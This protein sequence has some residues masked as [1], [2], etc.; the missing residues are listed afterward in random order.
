[1]NDNIN[2]AQGGNNTQTQGDRTFT[3]DD[4][5]RIVQERLAK[6]KAKSEAAIAQKEQELAKREL[7]LSAKEKLTE[8]GLP[9]ELLDALN[10]SSPEALDKS[11]EILEKIKT[12]Q[13]RTESFT[14]AAPGQT[15]R[16]GYDEGPDAK[17][18][19]AMGLQP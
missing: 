12:V 7:L 16:R 6:E 17:V 11:L 10:I 4:V 14:G 8:K 19:K 5:N 9:L 13:P 15:M 18:R 1:M 2:T 3:Q